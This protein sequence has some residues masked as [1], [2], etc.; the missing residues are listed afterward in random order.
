MVK[1]FPE[2]RPRGRRVTAAVAV[3]LAAG[4]LG[5][6]AGAGSTGKDAKTDR[7]KVP[8]VLDAGST[9]V[10]SKSHRVYLRRGVK[11]TQGDISV[12]ADDAQATGLDFNNTKWVFTGKVHIRSESQGDLH[13]DKANVDFSNNVLSRA[14]ATGSPAEFEQT[15]ST[16]G[17]LAKGHAS[18]IDYDVVAGTITLTGDAWLFDGPQR[19]DAPSI[20]YNVREKH[21]QGNSGATSGGRRVHMTIVPKSDPGSA[22]NSAPAADP[23]PRA[24]TAKP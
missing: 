17:T 9:D 16:T 15:Q 1:S 24:G 8:I 11:I 6:A 20:I 18:N 21:V 19:M 12:S 7:S 13:S 3:A 5:G 10:D 23:E 2:C 22:P 14:I 4:L